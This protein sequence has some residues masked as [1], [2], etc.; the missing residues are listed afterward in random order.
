MVT[1][2]IIRATYRGHRSG[3]RIVTEVF[4]QISCSRSARETRG[5]LTLWPGQRGNLP[6][7]ADHT[8]TVGAIGSNADI[9]NRIL[10]PQGLAQ[11]HPQG[12]LGRKD[13]DSRKHPGP[14][15]S[16]MAEQSIPSEGSPLIFDFLISIPLGSRAPARARG[17][18]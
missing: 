11:G 18:L 17:T 13:H 12:Q 9:E 14:R 7:H 5:Y 10:Q 15:P 4:G 1:P 2:S 6:G 3:S 8:E 16:S